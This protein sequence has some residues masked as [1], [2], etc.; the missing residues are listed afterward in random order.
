MSW[1][2]FVASKRFE[3]GLEEWQ[4]FT[5]FWKICQQFWEPEDN[6]EYWEQV[7]DST[8]EF[9]KKYKANNEIFA[10]K[11]ALVFIDTIEEKLK[12]ERKDSKP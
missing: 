10:R 12:Q 1:R 5:E 4:M 11:I 7:I 2:D 3:K 9:Y 8:N 6:D